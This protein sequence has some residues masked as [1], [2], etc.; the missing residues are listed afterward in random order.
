MDIKVEFKHIR[1]SRM[2][3]D[4]VY[5]WTDTIK[6]W[7]HLFRQ[8]KYKR[9]IIENL[10]DL[11]DKKMIVVY[12]FVIMPNHLHIL[13]EMKAKKGKEMP[14]ASFNK[15]TA[16][17]IV[18]DLDEN[19]AAVL[20]S[21][22]VKD[23]DR[24]FLIWQRDPLAILMDKREKLEQK[25]DYIHNNPL[26][27]KWNLAKRPEEYYWSSAKFYESNRDNFGFLTHYM[28]RI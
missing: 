19:H 6:D 18:N 1:N 12:G 15:V 23:K 3:L 11:V 24:S 16:Q 20:P 25:L 13:W 5:F 17:F 22:K 28:N 26:N 9:L 7:K 14:H 10:R 4:H 27:E 2:D 8:D 21:F